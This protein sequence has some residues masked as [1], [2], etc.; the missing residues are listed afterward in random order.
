MLP[1]GTVEEGIQVNRRDGYHQGAEAAEPAA[2]PDAA[3]MLGC[4]SGWACRRGLTQ[5]YLAR[6]AAQVSQQ[7]LGGIVAS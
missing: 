6:P 1:S 2:A 5:R 4:E 7:P 3:V